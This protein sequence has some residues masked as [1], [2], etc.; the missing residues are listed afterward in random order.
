M[1]QRRYP[2]SK[3]EAP[4]RVWSIASDS[5]RAVHGHCFNLSE[6][7]AGAIIAGP[8]Q[9]GQVVKMQLTVATEAQ[10]IMLEARLAYRN[11]LYCGFE[12]LGASEAVIRQVRNVCARA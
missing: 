10:P 12:F 9:P 11:R 1:D 8:W 4:M 5:A 7:G 3:I 2:R 6:G